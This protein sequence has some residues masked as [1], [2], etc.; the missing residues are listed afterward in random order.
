MI[1]LGTSLDPREEGDSEGAE[2]IEEIEAE[3]ALEVGIEEVIGEEVEGATEE[4]G[5]EEE[6]VLIMPLR[7]LIRE[8]LLSLR[9]QSKNC[10]YEDDGNIKC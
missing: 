3:V 9:D 4:V 1:W 2:G 5:E 8:I 7:M 6:V 10:D